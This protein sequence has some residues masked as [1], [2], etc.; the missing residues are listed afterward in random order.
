MKDLQ[1]LNLGPS[2]PPRGAPHRAAVRAAD[3]NFAIMILRRQFAALPTQ[4]P[5][6]WCVDNVIFAD[7][8]VTGRFNPTGREF[9][10]EIINDID[11][12][13]NREHTL[14]CSAGVGK[15]LAVMCRHVW[16]IVHHPRRAMMSM[17]ATKNAGGSE[18]YVTSRFI[19]CLEATAA[20]RDLMPAGQRRLFMNSKKVRLNGSHFDFVGGKSAS[21]VASN[22][23]SLIDVDEL[24]KQ[25]AAIGNEAG[26]KKLI[27]KR[28]EGVKDYTI[29]QNT[30]PTIETATGW[31]LLLRSD[32]RR[33]FLPCPHCNPEYRGRDLL[34]N[35]SLSESNLKGWMDLAWSEQY[36]VLPSKFARPPGAENGLLIPRAYIHWGEKMTNG[37]ATKNTL[38][39]RDGE[40]DLDG[41]IRSTRLQCPHCQGHIT[42][43]NKVWMDKN[44]VWIPLQENHGHK[45]Y[46]LSAL[47]A[48]PLVTREE[49]PK[50]QSRLAGRAL[51]FLE[52]VGDGESMKDFVNSIL[53]EVDVAQQHGSTKIEINSK[54]MAQPDWIPILTADYHKNHPYLWFIV[55][56]WCAF[57]LG[58]PVAIMDGKPEFV[59]ELELP[60]NESIKKI[61]E[62]L[63]SNFPR[64]A[65][66][67]PVASPAV[68]NVVGEL[69]RFNSHD[70]ATGHSPL[71]DFLLAQ[72]ITGEKLVKFFRDPIAEGGSD[73]NTMEFRRKILLEMFLQNGGRHASDFRAARGGDSELIAAGYCDRSGEYAWDELTEII[74]EFKIGQGLRIPARAVAVDCGF[75]ENK[76]RMVLQKCHE[77]ATE[78]DYYDPTIRGKE[79]YFS[80]RELSY[81]Q[82]HGWNG[83]QAIRGKPTFQSQGSGLGRDLGKH[84]EDPYFGTPK[85][86]T[87]VVDILE[88]PTALFWLRKDDI[89]QKRTK[90]ISTI[91][92]EISFFPKHFLPDGTRTE[93]SSYRLEDYQKQS[94]MMILDEQKNVIRSRAGTGGAQSKRHPDHPDDC[95]TYQVAM[96]THLEFFEVVSHHGPSGDKK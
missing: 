2:G 94:N 4:Q 26:L 66:R 28:T 58:P 88:I 17:P 46:H 95:E 7:T 96:A 21:A 3:W 40:W 23:C 6:D 75:A 1:E 52:D 48:P 37:A 13:E 62:E 25:P 15:T 49:D 77:S 47:Y 55:R 43:E 16:T 31:R 35:N 71:I 84:V 53:G 27:E 42:D 70:P 81:S 73:G 22:R 9:L 67:P 38:L 32:F 64:E 83:W 8:E 59:G 41:V 57:K 92:P 30:T 89:R 65:H 79:P 78:F 91:S 44:G 19:P 45:G 24:D 86:G 36:C 10:R 33:R 63:V 18:T 20:T 87:S 60:G 14:I 39:R 50:H 74:A 34:Q 61:C 5:F 29:F 51:K 80:D 72:K 85:G 54:P 56:K 90:H 68:W 12:T 76:N 93:K 69:A 11:D 82:T